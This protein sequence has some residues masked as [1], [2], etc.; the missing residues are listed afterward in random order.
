MSNAAQ[1]T[2]SYLYFADQVMNSRKSFD[3]NAGYCEETISGAMFNPLHWYLGFE[4]DP[5]LCPGGSRGTLAAK[6][7][8]DEDMLYSKLPNIPREQFERALGRLTLMWFALHRNLWRD[9]ATGG[10][11][12]EVVLEAADDYARLLEGLHK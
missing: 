6:L 9:G 10:E 12:K 4:D 3:I 2:M 8:I 1:V 11:C 5:E 7:G